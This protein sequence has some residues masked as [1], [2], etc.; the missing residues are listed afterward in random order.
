MLTF[1]PF[2]LSRVEG[3]TPGER[4]KLLGHASSDI[5]DRDYLSNLT[6]DAQSAFLQQKP[7]VDHIDKLRSVSTK[8]ALGLP[9]TLPAKK[10][11]DLLN[12]PT[13]IK[14]HQEPVPASGR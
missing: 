9:Q 10:M 7:R 13:A 4:N 12:D 3:A 2:F 8:R 11:A 14:L 5:G 6:L 1:A